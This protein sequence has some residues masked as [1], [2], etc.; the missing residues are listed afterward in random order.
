MQQ[1]RQ[2]QRR[3]RR[4]RADSQAMIAA[5]MTAS[6]RVPMNA[7]MT[8]PAAITAAS[9]ELARTTPKLCSRL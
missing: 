2:A 1:I 9:V 7:P 5:G 6:S 3:I 4:D 8:E